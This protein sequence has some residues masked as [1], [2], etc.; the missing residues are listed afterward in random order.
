MNNIFLIIFLGITTV[1]IAQNPIS[2]PE[3]PPGFL[4]R[5]KNEQER[6]KMKHYLDDL[7]DPSIINSTILLDDGEE[8]DC[9]DVYLQ[10]GKRKPLHQ[11]SKPPKDIGAQSESVDDEKSEQ[12]YGKSSSLCPEGTVPR[13]RIKLE[14][15]ERFE[16][17]GDYF[18]KLPS[19]LESDEDKL[20]R[21]AGP[22]NLHQYVVYYQD[23]TNYGAAAVLN[24]WSPYT[25][26]PNEFSLSQIWVRRGISSNLE[27]VEAGW[28]V[29]RD[30]YSD[31][32][33]RLFIFFTPDNYK[34]E[35]GGCYNLD[36]S[37]FVQTDSTI[38]IGGP[39]S[40][41]ST[42]G[43]PQKIIRIL[44]QQSSDGHWWFKFGDIWVGYWPASKFDTLGLRNGASRADFGGEITDKRNLNLHTSSDMGSGAFPSGGFGY[45][46]YTRSMVYINGPYSAPLSTAVIPS[47]VISGAKCYDG[48]TAFDGSSVWRRYIY[49]GGPGYHYANCY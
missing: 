35:G 39:F 38:Y 21:D 16:T 47:P 29:Y 37:A 33:A 10:H 23:V 24:L 19:H 48:T 8:I 31:S 40:Q 45:T 5:V 41:Y 2:K 25:E 34:K 13:R 1:V 43:G 28:Q 3:A 46:C 14:E 11:I 30:K 6:D 32:R 12:I 18:Q 27:T 17:L 15:L 44:L 22:T 42:S 20:K 49:F 7:N 36:C 4:V 26:L 9:V